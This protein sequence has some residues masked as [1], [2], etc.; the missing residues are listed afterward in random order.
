[1]AAPQ[2][3]SVSAK[4]CLRD[5]HSLF[6]FEAS[7]EDVESWSFSAKSRGTLWRNGEQISEAQ[8]GRPVLQWRPSGT[9]LDVAPAKV[10]SSR[11][12]PWVVVRDLAKGLNRLAEGDVVQLGRETLRVRQLSKQTSSIKPALFGDSCVC[13]EESSEAQC[14]ICL[15]EGSSPEDPFVQPCACSGSVAKVHLACLRQ[16]ARTRQNLPE[17][18]GS[19][20]R[21]SFQQPSCEMCKQPYPARIQRGET[22]EA[23]LQL[24]S[25]PGPFLVLESS[26]KGKKNGGQLRQGACHVLSFASSELATIGRGRDCS[27]RLDEGSMSRWH[28]S[29]RF[30]NG[31]FYIEDRGSKFGTFLSMSH[32]WTLLPG[33]SLPIKIGRTVLCIVHES[34]QEVAEGLSPRSLAS[35]TDSASEDIKSDLELPKL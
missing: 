19:L 26:G 21:C 18:Q 4:R 7:T 11:S 15:M 17:V 22:S 24:P 5:V 34:L 14:R 32:K 10:S 20:D 13:C 29:I 9:S 35:S 33:E 30:E 3:V 12:A 16:W 23:F 31:E 1:M 25:V 6:D 2:Q 27:I 28:A 8:E